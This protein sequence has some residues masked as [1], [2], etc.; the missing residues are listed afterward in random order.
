MIKIIAI[1]KLKEKHLK[2]LCDEYTKRIQ[3]YHKLEV[4]EV[5]DEMIKANASQK[6]E[7]AI[8]EKEGKEVLKRIKEQD[9]VMLLD[10]HGE[11]LRS[12]QL[13]NKIDTIL[14][15]HT[16]NITF[17]IGGSLGVSKELVKR[18]DFRLKLSDLTFLHQMTRY[19]ILEQIY[20]SFKINN[21]ETYHK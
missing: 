8:L 19:I 21:N 2:S 11:M 4:I 6:E 13:A 15:Y 7:Q 17:V 14:T 16:S 3:P 1:G 12:E 18:S 5:Q 10:L 9:Y 20:R